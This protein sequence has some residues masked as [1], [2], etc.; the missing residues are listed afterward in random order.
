MIAIA[1]ELAA[2]ELR[3][4]THDRQ[5]QAAATAALGSSKYNALRKLKC[6]VC[7]GVVEISGTVASF[8]LKQLAQTLVMHMEGVAGIRNLV[9][10]S[11]EPAVLV[12]TSCSA[13]S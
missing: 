5:V 7:E 1:N 2:E 8:Y 12:A 13:T 11:G 9:E 6:R 3:A 4:V 10:V